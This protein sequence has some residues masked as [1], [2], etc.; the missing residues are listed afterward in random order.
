MSEGEALVTSFARCL[1]C[2]SSPSCQQPAC[3]PYQP[4]THCRK[5]ENPGAAPSTLDLPDFMMALVHVAHLRWVVAGFMVALQNEPATQ[6]PAAYNRQIR[7]L[8]ATNVH[9]CCPHICCS[10][11]RRRGAAPLCSLQSRLRFTAHLLASCKTHRGA[12]RFQAESFASGP[13][14]TPLSTKLLSLLQ[15]SM[16]T[17]VLAELQRKLE[18]LRT[19]AIT[20]GTMLLLRKGRR[21]VKQ[22]N[23]GLL[24]P[25]TGSHLLWARTLCLFLLDTVRP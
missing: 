7:G 25:A 21:W 13:S 17:H 10:C 8:H 12:T 22:A 19:S 15:E 18:K 16:G 20:P 4:M 9:G 1:T 5:A 11:L 24:A 2:S 14:T 3:K 6:T 23:P